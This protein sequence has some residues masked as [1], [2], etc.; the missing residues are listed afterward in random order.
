M[1]RLTVVAVHEVVVE[2]CRAAGAADIHG[3]GRLVVLRARAEDG[4]LA[5]DDLGRGGLHFIS[6]LTSVVVGRR[7]RHRG[8]IL[9]CIIC[10]LRDVDRRGRSS[11]VCR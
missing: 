6:V 7:L 2:Q 9:I 1:Q 3:V 5:H 8:L 10:N 11:F 4:G